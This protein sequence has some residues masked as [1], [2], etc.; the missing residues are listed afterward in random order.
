MIEI[1]PHCGADVL[2]QGDDDV[3]PKCRKPSRSA[4]RRI[5]GQRRVETTVEPRV[6]DELKIYLPMG[7]IA[8]VL[9]NILVNQFAQGKNLRRAGERR[10]EIY[11]NP[12]RGVALMVKGGGFLI[13]AIP[14]LPFL[15]ARSWPRVLLS[16]LFT[17]GPLAAA[18]WYAV[19]SGWPWAPLAVILAVYWPVYFLRK[20]LSGRLARDVIALLRTELLEK[21][22][23][24]AT[25]D[26]GDALPSRPG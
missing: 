23:R 14:M 11:G 3:C 4:E 13:E 5:A 7:T 12:V 18:A 2:F 8:D 15:D 24:P 20:P 10:I 16:V 6:V 25:N 21:K 9:E 17:L 22:T 19:E 1:C 26:G